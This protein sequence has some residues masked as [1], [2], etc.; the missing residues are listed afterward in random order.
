MLLPSMI[1]SLCAIRHFQLNTT[2][3]DQGNRD[4]EKERFHRLR[5][6]AT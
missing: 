5:V 4:L 2:N 1:F 6:I 3:E